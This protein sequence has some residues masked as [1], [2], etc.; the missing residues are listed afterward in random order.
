MDEEQVTQGFCKS[1][2]ERLDQRM[3]ELV[4]AV[5]QIRDTLCCRD[6]LLERV[7][8]LEN[9]ELWRQRVET[10]RD[11]RQNEHEERLKEDRKD[12]T[13]TV[14]VAIGAVLA[15]VLSFLGNLVLF[16]IKTKGAP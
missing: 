9:N 4:E 15:A 6:G 10:E 8:I 1:T 2:H 12:R 14:R 7:R 3:G 11:R 13:N 16:F 5:N